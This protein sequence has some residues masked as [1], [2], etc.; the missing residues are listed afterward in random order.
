MTSSNIDRVQQLSDWLSAT[1]IDR[2]ELR[3]PGQHIRLQRE[4]GRI[5]AVHDEPALEHVAAPG[6]AAT[7]AARRWPSPATRYVA[8]KSSACCRSAP[9]FCR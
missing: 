9:C 5:V 3:G 7:A 2:L 1:D 6:I 4:A 8:G